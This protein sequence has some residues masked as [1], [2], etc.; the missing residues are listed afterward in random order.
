M[1]TRNKLVDDWLCGLNEEM[2]GNHAWLSRVPQMLSGFPW[3]N[4]HRATFN[5]VYCSVPGR[6]NSPLHSS[7]S[8][9]VYEEVMNVSGWCRV[10]L[11]GVESEDGRRKDDQS[12]RL[13][14][15]SWTMLSVFRERSYTLRATPLL[16][17]SEAVSGK[18]EGRWLQWLRLYD[19]VCM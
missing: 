7:S 11:S 15:A 16:A 12:G 14:V 4:Q 3:A 17:S 2:L 8:L 18:G 6:V 5:H 19:R 9:E 1:W 13:A 10:G